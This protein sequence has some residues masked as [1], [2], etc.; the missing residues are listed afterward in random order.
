MISR[1]QKRIII[2]HWGQRKSSRYI[3]SDTALFSQQLRRIEKC[4]VMVQILTF[5]VLDSVLK[6][7]AP[8]QRKIMRRIVALFSLLISFL[9][10]FVTQYRWVGDARNMA[11]WQHL[12]VWYHITTTGRDPNITSSPFAISVSMLMFNVLWAK[13]KPETKRCS[14]VNYMQSHMFLPCVC[15]WC[16]GRRYPRRF[17]HHFCIFL[18]LNRMYQ[19]KP[20]LNLFG[21]LNFLGFL[22]FWAYN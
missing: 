18:S 6:V 11:K 10:A 17:V 20:A 15:C 2:L 5:N 4:G 7:S 12:K 19:L 22:N 16:F 1:F 13:H 14:L 9:W 21:V 3:H 8:T